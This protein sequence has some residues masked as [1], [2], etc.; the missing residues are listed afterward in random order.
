[1]RMPL[2]ATIFVVDDDPDVLVSLRFL[3]ETEGFTVRTFADGPALLSSNLPAANDC[4]IIDY[5]MAGMDGL[6]LVLKLR[7]R[8]IST[9]VVLITGY[10]NSGIAAKAAISGIRHLVLKPHI[11][12][13]LIAHVQAAMDEQSAAEPPPVKP[14][15]FGP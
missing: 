7:D 3:L 10:S 11:E 12:E 15:G 8:Q 5:W 13:S 1:M 9:P 2:A 6:E 14:L 4:L